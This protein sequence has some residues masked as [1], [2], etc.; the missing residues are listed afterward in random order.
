MPGPVHTAIQDKLRGELH[1]QKL[2][3]RN[4]SSLHAHHHA[5]VV[6]GGGNGETHFAVTAISERFN[7][8]LQIQRHRLVN[9]LLTEEFEKMGLHALSLRLYTQQE[10]ERMQKQ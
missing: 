7:G 1:P 5:M 10:A 2:E 4:D 6:Q 9:R 8:M 3:V